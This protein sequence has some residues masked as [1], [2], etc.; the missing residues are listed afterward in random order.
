[1]KTETFE[2]LASR[3]REYQQPNRSSQFKK[4]V[5][6]NNSIVFPT[7]FGNEL[8]IIEIK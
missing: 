1:M 3:A 7:E 5:H 4:N 2:R 8:E 6:N